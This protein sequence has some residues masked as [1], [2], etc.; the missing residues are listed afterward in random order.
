MPPFLRANPGPKN[1]LSHERILRVCR[2]Y[3]TL[4]EKYIA[5][6]GPLDMELYNS[7]LEI[8]REIIRWEQRAAKLRYESRRQASYR[9]AKRENADFGATH[10][11]TYD[12]T[13]DTFVA[14]ATEAD[15]V[16][17]IPDATR[18]AIARFRRG[19]RSGGDEEENRP[20]TSEYKKSGL[21]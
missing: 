7:M 4:H 6:G 21:V 2:A 14:E 5:L 9:A 16:P 17:V 11:A 8:D 18:E 10:N 19:E 15:T 12:G 20:D 1:P 13:T 3:K